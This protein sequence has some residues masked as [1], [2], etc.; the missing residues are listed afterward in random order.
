M[1]NLA[2]LLTDCDARGIRLFL[3]GDGGLTIDAP[4]DTVTPDLIERLKAHK[5]ELL[6]LLRPT[7]E[8]TPIPAPSDADALAT[9]IRPV[10][11]CGSTR[12]RDVPIHHGQSVRRDC[13]QCR[14]FIGFPIWY[15]EGTLQTE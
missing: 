9:P 15:G 6:T 1:T 14:R 10:C 11:R 3:A 5:S 12:W 13:G 8:A 7:P 2:K 4:Q